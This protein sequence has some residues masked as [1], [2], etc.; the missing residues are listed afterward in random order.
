[1]KPQRPFSVTL[2]A[3]GVLTIASLNLVRLIQAVRQWSFLASLPAESPLYLVLTALIWMA[4]GGPLVWGLWTGKQWAPSRCYT[5]VLAYTVYFWWERLFLF[6]RPNGG[7]DA[8]SLAYLPGQGLFL[9]VATILFLVF[10]LW[11]LRRPGA[12]KYFGT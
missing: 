11:T 6:G 4:A 8:P 3:L 1:M 10:V 7:L 12:K 2:L 5:F 9:A